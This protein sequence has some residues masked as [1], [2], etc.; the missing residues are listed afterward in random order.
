MAKELNS[1]TAD[2]KYT[3]KKKIRQIQYNRMLY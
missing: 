1:E 2:I 3:H